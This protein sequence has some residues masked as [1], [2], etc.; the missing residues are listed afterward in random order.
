[1]KKDDTYFEVKDIMIEAHLTKFY[2]FKSFINKK[3]PKELLIREG[4]NKIPFEF[5]LDGKTIYQKFLKINAM[6]KFE[7]LV[8]NGYIK[9]SD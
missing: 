2:K 8:E 6:V 5:K 9:F 7:Q 4:E 1:M 3:L